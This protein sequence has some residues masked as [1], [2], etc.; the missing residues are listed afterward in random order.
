MFSIRRRKKGALV[1]ALD[2]KPAC[3]QRGASGVRTDSPTTS[4]PARAGESASLVNQIIYM[5][6]WMGEKE[7][8]KGRDFRSTQSNAFFD[9]N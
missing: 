4:D 1:L 9:L 3:T 6:G 8:S 5:I 2:R 7:W